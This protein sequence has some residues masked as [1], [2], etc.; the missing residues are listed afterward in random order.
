MRDV[1]YCDIN[2]PEAETDL[3]E[4]LNIS[5]IE[6]ITV[7]EENFYILSNKKN[8]KLGFYLFQVKQSNPKNELLKGGKIKRNWKQLISWNNKLDIGDTDIAIMTEEKKIPG[9]K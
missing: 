1:L 2:N 4:E 8:H 3:D 9:S 7:D 6:N 5:A